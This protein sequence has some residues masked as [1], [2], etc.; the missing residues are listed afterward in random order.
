METFVFSLLSGMIAAVVTSGF[1]IYIVFKK[2]RYER[3]EKL[4]QPLRYKLLSMRLLIQNYKGL[5]A[6]LDKTNPSDFIQRLAPFRAK[7]NN[8]RVEIRELFSQNSAFI[9]LKDMSLVAKFIDADMKRDICDEDKDQSS[10]SA[11]RGSAIFVAIEELQKRF[12]D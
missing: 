10:I 5:A 2:K 4:Y 7:W 9:E 6:E 8:Y 11:S 12:L 3:S 1:S